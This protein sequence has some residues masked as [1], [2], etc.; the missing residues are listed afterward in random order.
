MSLIVRKDHNHNIL[1]LSSVG[2]H[3]SVLNQYPN[4]L[5]KNIMWFI[6]EVEGKDNIVLY[7]SKPAK[8]EATHWEIDDKYII[9]FSQERLAV[10]VS[11]KRLYALEAELN[12][13]GES[14]WD[15]TNYYHLSQALT[16]L[17]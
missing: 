14:D 16:L 10:L 7:W 4:G 12:N 9:P 11:S 3:T 17:T 8:P 5:D 13:N 1:M 2:E 6:H 15:L